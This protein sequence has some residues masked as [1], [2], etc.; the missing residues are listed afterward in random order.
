MPKINARLGY[1]ELCRRALEMADEVGVDR[2]YAWRMSR[3]ENMDVYLGCDVQKIAS[4][5]L[6]DGGCRD[7]VVLLPISRLGKDAD[8]LEFVSGLERDSVGG[9]L[10][11]LPR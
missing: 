6:L 1:G 7:G 2:F 4:A 10:I 9:Y 8:M 11:A 5:E 3:P